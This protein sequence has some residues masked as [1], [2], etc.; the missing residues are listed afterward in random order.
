MTFTGNWQLPCQSHY[1]IDQGEI[2]WAENGR[3]SKSLRA[4]EQK[5]NDGMLTMMLIANSI[6]D[7]SR[8]FGI[9]L[10]NILSERQG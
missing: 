7:S 3:Q 2:I 6:L 10:L 9:G 5:K 4:G 1:W 8:G